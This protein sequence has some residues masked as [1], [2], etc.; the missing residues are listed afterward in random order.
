LASLIVEDVVASKRFYVDLFGFEPQ[1]DIGWFVSLVHIPGKW[2]IC[3]SV[4]SGAVRTS[5]L[6]LWFRRSRVQVLSV[7]P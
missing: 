1:V 5:K 4:P 6:E 3:S 2:E 7:T